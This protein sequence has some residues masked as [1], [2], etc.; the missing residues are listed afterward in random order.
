MF[1]IVSSV[2]V[3]IS[4]AFVSVTLMRG[5]NRT[6]LPM[7]HSVNLHELANVFYFVLNF[8]PVLDLVFWSSLLILQMFCFNLYKHLIL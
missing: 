5:F 8:T 1:R 4:H 3:G 7:C 6:A 2:L